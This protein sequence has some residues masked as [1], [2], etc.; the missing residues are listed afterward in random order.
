MHKI[1]LIETSA[2]LRHAMKKSLVAQSY[3]VAEHKNF[4]S[5]LEHLI[6]NPNEYDGV[7]LGWPEQT[8]TSTDELLSVLCDPPYDQ[9]PLIVLS[10]DADSAKLGWISGRKNSA[11]ILWDTFEDTVKTLPKLLSNQMI[12]PCCDIETDIAIRV[13]IV[14]D[15]PTARVKFRRPLEQCGC[16]VTTASCS[17]EALK[18][19]TEEDFDIAIIDYYMPDQNGDAV[20]QQLRRNPKQLISFLQF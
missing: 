19:A 16:T 6:E 9:T 18:V 11:F 15:S 7:V 17:T 20:C 12:E 10:H 4:V 5:G 1:L 14:D 2:T 3:T 13:L 8:N